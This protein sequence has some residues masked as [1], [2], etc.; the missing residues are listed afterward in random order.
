MRGILT[1]AVLCLVAVGLVACHDIDEPEADDRH[2]GGSDTDSESDSETEEPEGPALLTEVVFEGEPGGT[3]WGGF[4]T[5]GKD[6]DGDGL[7]EVLVLDYGGSVPDTTSYPDA[8]GAV[9]VFYGRESFDPEY[10]VLD[11]DAILR[12]A[13]EMATAA[14][15]LNGDELGD[16]A[17]VSQDGAHIVY[18]NPTRLS[19]ELL[20]TS[21]G[22]HVT[23][24]MIDTEHLKFSGRADVNGDELDDLL[25]ETAWH[26]SDDDPAVF[27]TYLVLGHE[28]DLPSS[29]DLSEADAV[30]TGEGAG[31]AIQAGADLAGDLDGDGFSEV[32]ITLEDPAPESD[33][34]VGAAL[35]YGGPG[36]FSGTISPDQAD[37]IFVTPLHWFNLRGLGDLDNDGFG[38]FVIGD[39]E[40]I[41]GIY[42]SDTRFEGVVDLSVASFSLLSGNGV[43]YLATITTADLNGDTWLDVIVGDPHEAT[44]GT[45]TGALF[46]IWGDGDRLSGDYLLDDEYAVK[47]GLNYEEEDLGHGENLGYG[48]GGGGDVNGDGYADILVGAVGDVIGDDYGGC[49]Y[50]LLGGPPE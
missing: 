44:N 2:D 20:S 25:I 50:L 18:G 38:D 7:D 29:L 4:T 17:F 39:E 46:V 35:F 16:I 42:G 32:L 31:Y 15:D 28:E 24:P 19:G 6:M 12:G 9:Y 22:V 1:A 36:V 41:P 21:V 26:P 27:A 37:A 48:L 49:V 10:S 5:V 14:G 34:E 43:S 23:G 11:A 13:G 30:F 40:V 45:Q 47:Y 33:G 8:R 3:A